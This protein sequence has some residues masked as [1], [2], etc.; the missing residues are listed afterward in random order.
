MLSRGLVLLHDNARPHTA[1]QTQALITS[2]GWE[3]F[4]Y[5]PPP[6]SYSPD[7]APSDFHVFLRLKKILADQ[8]FLNDDDVKEAVNKWRLHRRLRSTRRGQRNWCLVMINAIIVVETIKKSSLWYRESDKNNISE[9]NFG[10]FNSLTV[11]TFRIYVVLLLT[12]L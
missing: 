3:Q 5:P 6:F 7:L 10:F 2:F 12:A 8:R 9:I 4:E 11:L 1:A